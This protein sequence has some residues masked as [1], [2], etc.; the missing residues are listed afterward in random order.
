MPVEMIWAFGLGLGAVLLFLIEFLVPSAGIIGAVSFLL[1]CASIYAFFQVGEW[2]GIASVGIY[3]V[4]I[5]IAINFALKV[6]PHTPIGRK[7]MLGGPDTEEEEAR[8]RAERERTEREQAAALIGAEGEAL[9][10]LRPV[11]SV[12]IEG[13]RIEALAEGAMIDA[14][15]RVRVVKVEGS[16]VKVRRID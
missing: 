7:L 16:Q 15:T 12:K 9:T 11:G 3:M 6:M 14:G 8:K 5:P 13:M 4:L 1:V 10:D 2:W